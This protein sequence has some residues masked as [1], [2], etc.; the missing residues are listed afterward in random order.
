MTVIWSWSNSN[1]GTIRMRTTRTAMFFK[2]VCVVWD[3]GHLTNLI[4][5]WCWMAKTSFS[6]TTI[7][8]CGNSLL[9]KLAC[10]F[11]AIRL[12]LCCS[13]TLP[14]LVLYWAVDMNKRPL[15]RRIGWISKISLYLIICNITLSLYFHL[16]MPYN[17][18]LHLSE[19]M[20]SWLGSIGQIFS[21]WLFWICPVLYWTLYWSHLYNRHHH[22]CWYSA[23]PIM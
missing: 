4:Q 23:L 8:F 7:H 19:H 16:N 13:F 21:S 22:F 20:K 14:L 15:Y 17:I 3:S 11:H 6:C 12:T 1:W 5:A 2:C 10:S 18:S 9:P